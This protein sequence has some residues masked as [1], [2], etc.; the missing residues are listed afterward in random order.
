MQNRAIEIC[1]LFFQG[2]LLF[3]AIFLAMLYF[4]TRRADLRNYFIF[5]LLSS[6]YFFLNAPDTFFGIPDNNIFNSKLYLNGNIHS[7]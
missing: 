1:Y 5:L 7:L 2:M 4:V 6:A 3:Q